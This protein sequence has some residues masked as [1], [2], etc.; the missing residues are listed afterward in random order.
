MK[1]KLL[2]TAC[3]SIWQK[4]WVALFVLTPCP[5]TSINNIWVSTVSGSERVGLWSAAR[6]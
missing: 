3:W 6:Y 4:I 2:P 5:F 1:N